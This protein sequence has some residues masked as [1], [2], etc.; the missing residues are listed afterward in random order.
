METEW[1][2]SVEVLEFSS[3]SFMS[4]SKSFD[5]VNLSF[6]IYKALVI[7][8]AFQYPP[9]TSPGNIFFSFHILP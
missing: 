5:F 9:S 7:V 4:F 3:A 1:K 2:I 8:P 6:F